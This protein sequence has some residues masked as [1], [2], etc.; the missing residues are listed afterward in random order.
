VVLQL[1]IF[2]TSLINGSKLQIYLY[3]YTHI[4][5]THTHI[6]DSQVVVVYPF[7]AHPL[8]YQCKANL[9]AKTVS[10]MEMLLQAKNPFEV[11]YR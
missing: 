3:I 6:R 8:N 1:K 9:K 2:V 4:T 10:C 5:H 11:Y 7:L